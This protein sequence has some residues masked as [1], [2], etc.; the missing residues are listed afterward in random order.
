MPQSN[1][2]GDLICATPV[3]R[4]IKTR[5]P[6]S[7]LA[8]LVSKRSCGVI[9]NNPRINEIILYED[10]D[11]L[12]KI[13]RLNFHWSFILTNN[14]MH[15][16]IA[17]LGLIPNRVKTTAQTKSKSELFTDFLNNYTLTYENH[18]YL[19]EHYLK[20]LEFINIKDAEEVKEVFLQSG[21]D[22]KAEKFLLDNKLSR[23]DF[24]VGCS[25][26]AGNKIKEWGTANFAALS[27]ILIEHY[28]ARIIFFGAEKDKEKILETIKKMRKGEKTA[29]ATDFLLEEVPSLIKMLK[30]FISVDTGLLYIANALGVYVIDIIGPCDPREQPPQNEKSVLV[31][32]PEHIKPSSFVM[33][34]AGTRDEHIRA[35]NSIKVEDVLKGFSKLRL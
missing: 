13:R 27:D 4:A 31:T 26:T 8:V 12:K 28:N 22:E 2:I 25:V 19:P 6:D 24:L 35:T 1:R 14:P 20:L 10:R 29:I 30:V 23:E 9:K 21:A 15:S 7:Y 33:K 32:P 18:T 11:L 34:R 16:V 3:F 17:Y 5:Y